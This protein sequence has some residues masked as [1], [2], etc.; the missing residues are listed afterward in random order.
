MRRIPCACEA[1]L[2]QLKQPWDAKLER[3]DQPRYS[4]GDQ[5]CELWPIFEGLNDWHIVELSRVPAKIAALEKLAQEELFDAQDT[6]LNGIAEEMAEGIEAGKIGAFS[7]EDEETSGY[8][9]VEWKS[10]AYTLQEDKVLTEFDPPLELQ[11]GELVVNATYLNL[12]PRAPLWYTQSE[13]STTVRVKQVLA[14]NLNMLGIS[15]SNKVPRGCNKKEVE[16]LEGK[17]LH[18]VDHEEILDERMR[19]VALDHEEIT[20]AEYYD[21][22][23]ESDDLDDEDDNGDEVQEG[24]DNEE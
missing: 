14:A 18:D 8:Y 5:K 20:S 10:E 17:R 19:R 15:D 3:K 4:K 22:G 24:D 1:C 13:L 7:T 6:I 2:E 11:A 23:D 9:L 21:S 12:V 16:R